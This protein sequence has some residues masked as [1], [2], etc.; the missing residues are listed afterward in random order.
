VV[1]FGLAKY[2][3]F[4]SAFAHLLSGCGFYGEA[5][6]IMLKHS[7]LLLA[8][9][10]C[11]LV[12]FAMMEDLSLLAMQARD[13][14]D[15]FDVVNRIKAESLGKQE[16]ISS[17]IYHLNQIKNHT[18]DDNAVLATLSNR[19]QKDQLDENILAQ[20][21]VLQSM[22]HRVKRKILRDMYKSRGNN[23]SLQSDLRNEVAYI[24]VLMRSLLDQT[25]GRVIRSHILNHTSDIYFPNNASIFYETEVA[26]NAF[27]TMATTLLTP[28]FEA[29]YG[30]EVDARL[31]W[32]ERLLF[33]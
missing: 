21:D 24:M 17:A 16:M 23:V 29:R 1:A 8:R 7:R 11:S 4:M 31:E 33:Q 26:N 2:S 18:G 9:D 15:V 5:R 19:K 10:N 14:S 20:L 3:D 22:R 28:K 30:E 25:F 12:A 27:S 32:W 6:D 13:S